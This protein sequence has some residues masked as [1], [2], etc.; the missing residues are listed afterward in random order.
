MNITDDLMNIYTSDNNDAGVYRI[1]V[2]NNIQVA[3]YDVFTLTVFDECNFENVTLVSPAILGTF[4]Y[5]VYS[6]NNETL[7]ITSWTSSNA[8]CI[9]RII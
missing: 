5:D 1:K 4:Q 7:F 9:P 2:Y 6:G 3:S 8:N